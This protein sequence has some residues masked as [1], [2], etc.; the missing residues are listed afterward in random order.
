M[1]RSTAPQQGQ[2][3]GLVSRSAAAIIDSFVVA[4]VASIL[5]LGAAGLLFALRLRGF[6]FPR[7]G[8]GLTLLMCSSLTLIYLGM[9][10][11]A[12]GRTVGDQ[13]AGLRILDRSGAR[14]R[15]LNAYARVLL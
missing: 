3:A 2:R 6:Q 12:S 9:C 13:L 1:T 4:L 8:L 7:P 15:P 14:V 11:S 10:W 5:Y